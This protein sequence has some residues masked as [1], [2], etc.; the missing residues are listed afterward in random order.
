MPGTRAVVL[1]LVL[2]GVLVHACVAQLLAVTDGSN[3]M[4][5]TQ[6]CCRDQYKRAHTIFDWCVLDA[7]VD[8]SGSGCVIRDRC[9]GAESE[10]DG[11]RRQ[12][13]VPGSAVSTAAT[14]AIVFNSC[15]TDATCQDGIFCNGIE[16]CE[17]NAG[18]GNLCINSGV[19]ACAAGEHCFETAPSERRCQATC[20]SDADCADNNYCNG[21]ETCRQSAIDI[22][23]LVCY[24]GSAPCPAGSL[25]LNATQTCSAGCTHALCDDMCTG[26]YCSDL[27]NIC[28]PG[29]YTPVSCP[30]SQTCDPVRGCVECTVATSLVLCDDMDG[31]TTDSCDSNVCRHVEQCPAGLVCADSVRTCQVPCNLTT[32][33]TCDGNACEYVNNTCVTGGPPVVCSPQQQCNPL[34]GTCQNIPCAL[35]AQC[36]NSGIFCDGRS[37]CN[38]LLGECHVVPQCTGA[39]EICLEDLRQ[40]NNVCAVDTDCSFPESTYCDNFRPCDRARDYCLTSRPRCNPVNETCDPFNRE[41]VPGGPTTTPSP[42]VARVNGRAVFLWV[43]V[44]FLFTLVFCI[45]G[46]AIIHLLRP[47][48]RRAD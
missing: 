31:C 46:V 38:L 27:T 2:A 15:F 36:P 3:T 10:C 4:C 43:A 42:S 21:A 44:I 41:C 23:V 26:T 16:V 37:G 25:C 1:L 6:A 17:L 45:L 14:T 48:S 7:D 40:C 39:D 22:S 24:A 18:E 34:F 20:A 5:T 47:R 28:T 8:A 11:L 29:Y 13:L 12:C 30:V 33:S 9:V 35:D 19:P 32:C